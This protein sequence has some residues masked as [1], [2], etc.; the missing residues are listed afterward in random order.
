MHSLGSNLKVQKVCSKKKISL[1]L[2]TPVIQSSL[3]VTNDVTGF[4]SSTQKRYMPMCLH[5]GALGA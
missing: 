3:L 4:C 1:S 5:F 2:L